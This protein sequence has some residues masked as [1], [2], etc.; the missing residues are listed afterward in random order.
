MDNI[1][2]ALQLITEEYW[3]FVDDKEMRIA[4]RLD[5]IIGKIIEVQKILEENRK[6]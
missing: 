5:T 2:E 3:N 6:G 1:K 4:N